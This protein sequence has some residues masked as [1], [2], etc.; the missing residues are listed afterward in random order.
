MAPRGHCISDLR[1]IGRNVGEII[2]QLE[3]QELRVEQVHPAWGQQIA[4]KIDGRRGHEFAI[5]S[6][7]VS[8]KCK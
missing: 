8:V 1:H 4:S 6:S 7:P 5:K 2:P 3:V